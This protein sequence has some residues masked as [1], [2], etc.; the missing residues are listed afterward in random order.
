MHEN[1]RSRL[2]D[3]NEESSAGIR[4]NSEPEVTIEAP[5]KPCS[6]ENKT[7]RIGDELEES[8]ADNRTDL[9]PIT[10][11]SPGPTTS[12]S[13]DDV[14]IVGDVQVARPEVIDLEKLPTIRQGKR[15]YAVFTS[16]VSF[17]IRPNL[18]RTSVNTAL[19][20]FV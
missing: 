18:F 6:Q 14:M 11:E 5:T 10:V 19:S 4:T 17:M 9:E 13:Q 2:D 12:H 8:S 3:E 7:N 1:K 15:S 20:S 16:A